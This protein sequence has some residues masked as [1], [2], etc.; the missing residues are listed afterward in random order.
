MS[1]KSKLMMSVLVGSLMGF[2][3]GVQANGAMTIGTNQPGSLFY[4]TGVA[5]SEALSRNGVDSRVQS[6]AGSGP[7][8]ALV[9]QGALDLAVINVFEMSQ[10][11][12]GLPPFKNPHPNLRVV[13]RL[14]DGQIGA[15]VAAKSDIKSLADI[16]GKRMTAGYAA[17]PIAELMRKAIVANAGLTDKDIVT[18]SVPN[19]NRSGELLGSGRVDVGFLAVGSGSAEE[20]NASLGGIRFLSLD[21][22]E[23]AV[24]ALQEIMPQGYPAT[25]TNREAPPVGTDGDTQVLTYG[26]VLVTHKDYDSEKVVSILQA[27]EDN[28]AH[29]ES[30]V[31]NFQGIDRAKMGGALNIPY[32]E[33]ASQHLN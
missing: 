19:A 5:V 32:H 13:A 2:S 25:V 4:S 10:A 6:Y 12:N 29:L 17:S 16:K 24:F 21:D 11:A 3:T 15:V 22:S 9:D 23:E 28:V 7:L 26:V 18:V 30:S 33:A 27:L 8:M 14:F 31:T 1:I 20:L